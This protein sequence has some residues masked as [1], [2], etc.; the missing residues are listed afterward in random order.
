MVAVTLHTPSYDQLPQVEISKATDMDTHV[1]LGSVGRG[2]KKDGGC[3][4]ARHIG[5]LLLA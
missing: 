2:K 1:N 3:N 5:P 4:E